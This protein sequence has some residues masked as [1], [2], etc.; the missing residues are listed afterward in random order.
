MK[1]YNDP[2]LY[3]VLRPVAKVLLKILYRPKIIGTENIPKE[4]SV[5]RKPY[6]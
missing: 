4:G 1:K 5:S 6:A 3:K 2:L